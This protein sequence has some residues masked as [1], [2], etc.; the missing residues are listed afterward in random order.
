MV[1]TTT[2]ANVEQRATNVGVHELRAVLLIRHKVQQ[3]PNRELRHLAESSSSSF[4]RIAH[5][6]LSDWRSSEI[7]PVYIRSGARSTLSA[8]ANSDPAPSLRSLSHAELKFRKQ[9]A[10]ILTLASQT[11]STYRIICENSKILQVAYEHTDRSV[12]MKFPHTV[13]CPRKS[14]SP[15]PL[16]ARDY[17]LELPTS[18]TD[19][20]QIYKVNKLP[21]VSM[22]A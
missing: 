6:V 11:V 5:F 10:R 2:A 16:Q 4:R 9:I 22:F 15:T 14:D 17:S 19:R 7:H 1:Y 20:G 18:D 13:E 12:R 3:R 21:N 8:H